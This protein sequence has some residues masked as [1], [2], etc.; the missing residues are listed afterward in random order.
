MSKSDPESAIF[1]DDSEA[2]VNRKIKKAF[3]K[4][5]IVQNNPIMDYYK[6]I[7]FPYIEQEFIETQSED[8]KYLT[9]DKGKWG[10]LKTYYNYN[11]FEND[12]V[13]GDL[14]QADIKPKL[15]KEI[16]RM[17]QPIRDHFKTNSSAKALM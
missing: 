17:L 8:K 12:F 16:N 14:H 13:K 5:Q 2:D 6:H 11:E 15:Q 1:M 10:G 4:P 9:I 7:V 3:C